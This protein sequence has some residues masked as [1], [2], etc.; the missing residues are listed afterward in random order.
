[1]WKTTFSDLVQIPPSQFHKKNRE[2]IEDKINEKYANKVGQA[3]HSLPSCLTENS[4]S[5][6]KL[7]SVY[8]FTIF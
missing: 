3:G 7:G 5:S 2:V 1:M 8:V 6:T 4:R